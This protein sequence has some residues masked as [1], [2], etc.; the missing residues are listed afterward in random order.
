MTAAGELSPEILRL[1]NTKRSCAASCLRKYYW[2]YERHLKPRIGSTALRY[3]IVWHAAMDA[4][5]SHISEHG[6]KRDGKA[7]E[8]AVLTARMEW[9]EYS[10][11]Q[12][13]YDDYRSLPNLMQSMLTYMDHFSYDEGMLKILES[14]QAFEIPMYPETKE[15]M[16]VA[17]RWYT[18]K[19]SGPHFIFTGMID[20][21][22]ELNG[23][24]WIID[25][26]TT[27][28][29]ISRMAGQLRRSPQF[30]GYS[31]AA[32]KKLKIIPD[33]FLVIIHHLSAYKSKTTGDYGKP[34]IDFDRIPEIY[35][36]YDLSQWRISIINTA[37]RVLQCKSTGIWPMEFNNCY[38]FGQCSFTQLCDQQRPIQDVI[39]NDNFIVGEPWDITKE[40]EKRNLRRQA[41]LRGE[42]KF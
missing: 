25:H 2:E 42:V 38:T 9:A 29:A 28:Q 7:L 13:F 37:A 34:K 19:T 6:W 32:S 24:P 33:G 22:V 5:Y 1:D 8:I 10:K 4:F 14:E 18:E 36:A 16:K 30:I 20:L 41:L 27:G 40:T 23:Q 39:Y 11:N 21:E 35:T 31:Y 15:E 12:T 26:K 17:G 3:G